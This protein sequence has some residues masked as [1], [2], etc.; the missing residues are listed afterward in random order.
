M[1]AEDY[2]N[3]KDEI[4]QID[5]SQKFMVSVITKDLIKIYNSN[6]DS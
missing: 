4:N 1:I 3:T 2:D 6:I 5:L